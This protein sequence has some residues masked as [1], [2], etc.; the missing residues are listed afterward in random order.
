MTVDIPQ[1]LYCTILWIL[2]A[3]IYIHLETKKKKVLFKCTFYTECFFFFLF[4]TSQHL[5]RGYSGLT[6][7]GHL[8]DTHS[9]SSGETT[10]S[11][12]GRGGSEEDIR[13]NMTNSHDTG[14]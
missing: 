12:S 5:G 7:K 6:R 14:S 1:V 3:H 10:T 4:C 9:E 2:N 8:D 11:D 13:S